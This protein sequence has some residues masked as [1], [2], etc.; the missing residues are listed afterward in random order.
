MVTVG[1]R[2]ILETIVERFV[3]QGFTRLYL[4][5]NYRKEMIE[6][7]FGDGAKWGA[8]I[9]YLHEDSPRG[10]A[11]ALAQVPKTETRP[12]IVMNGDLVTRVDFRHLAAF[13]DQHGGLATMAVSEARFAVPYGVAAIKADVLTGLEEKPVKSFFVNAGI[14]VL[15]PAVIALIDTP[16]LAKHAINMNN[17]FSILLARIDDP[18]R[19]PR[20]FALREYWIDVGRT[21]DL[22]QARSDSRD[23]I[24][25]V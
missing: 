5:V 14:Y 9:T 6:D 4:S 19:A 18:Q 2:P 20:V 12:L 22:E 17:L 21:E 13:H 8:H 1:G 24:R 7:Y 15:D 25:E 23:L 16:A 10:T 11:A 3:R